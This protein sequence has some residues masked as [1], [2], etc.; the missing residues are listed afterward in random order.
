MPPEINFVTRYFIDTDDDLQLLSRIDLVD[1][2]KIKPPESSSNGNGIDYT[3]DINNN[4]NFV[5]SSITMINIAPR[6]SWI[7]CI[8]KTFRLE[9]F[10]ENPKFNKIEFYIRYIFSIRSIIDLICF[11]PILVYISQVENTIYNAYQVL[12]AFRVIRLF[13]LLLTIK[14]IRYLYDNHLQKYII[15]CFFISICRPTLSTIYQTFNV[16]RDL[17][18]VIFVMIIIGCV[19]FGSVMFTLERGTYTVPTN[20][21]IGYYQIQA[22]NQIQTQ[23]SLFSSS[24]IYL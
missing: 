17:L 11:L 3:N 23:T 14:S 2:G 1:L 7:D 5:D 12:S 13:K 6:R 8:I 19:F 15:Y 20:S 4:D 16:V 21:T 22:P 10:E 24:G 9:P 18:T